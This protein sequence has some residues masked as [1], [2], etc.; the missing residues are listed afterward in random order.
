MAVRRKTSSNLCLYEA[1]FFHLVVES[2]AEI[3]SSPYRALCINMKQIRGY[4]ILGSRIP[5]TGW[6]ESTKQ[7]S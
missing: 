7:N 5:K 3:M 1:F 2:P 6:V 4:F